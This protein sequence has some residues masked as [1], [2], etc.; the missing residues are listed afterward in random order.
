MTRTSAAPAGDIIEELARRWRSDHKGAGQRPNAA[1]AAV[2]NA[3]GN[4]PANRAAVAITSLIE[5][6][7]DVFHA[8]ETL[9][10]RIQQRG[11]GDRR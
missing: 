8:A 5:P 7:D 2:G 9:A 10:R 1:T 4:P 11:A 3:T 6:R